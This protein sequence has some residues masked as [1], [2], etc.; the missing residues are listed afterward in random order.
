MKYH[1]LFFGK[2]GKLSQNLLSAG[3]VI[4]ALRVKVA[5]DLP[6]T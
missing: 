5:L 4:A 2:L 3:V 6:Y 1:T